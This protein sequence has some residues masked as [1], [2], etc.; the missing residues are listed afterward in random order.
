[1]SPKLNEL[2][3]R[4]YVEDVWNAGNLE[5]VDEL[6]DPNH[7]RHDPILSDDVI[8]TESIKAQIKSLRTG[9]PDLNFDVKIYPAADGIHVTRQW[10]LTGTHQGKWMGIKPTGNHITNTGMAISRIA[11]GTIAEEWIQ[12]DEIG[13]RKQ[14]GQA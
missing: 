2:L 9:L 6:L 12:R 1:M 13:L 5:L 3:V 8:G 14:I 4:R 10:I 11:N 7:I